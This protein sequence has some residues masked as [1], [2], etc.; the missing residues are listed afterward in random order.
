[1]ENMN[2]DQIIRLR[3]EAINRLLSQKA[4]LQAELETI[5]ANLSEIEG[6][7]HK[8]GYQP[9]RD[10]SFIGV[11][12]NKPSKLYNYQPGEGFILIE[13]GE[14]IGPGSTDVEALKAIKSWCGK[15]NKTFYPAQWKRIINPHYG[16][17]EHKTS[18]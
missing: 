13:T 18:L 10:S 14:L 5:T 11:T 3:E 6:Q 9:P 12:G 1:M 7:L 17:S 2:V 4:Q 8:L 15:V 16:R